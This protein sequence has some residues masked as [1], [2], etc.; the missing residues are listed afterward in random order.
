MFSRR[1]PLAGALAGLELATVAAGVVLQGS[2][3]I[4]GGANPSEEKATRT[5]ARNAL[6]PDS[7]EYSRSVSPRAMVGTTLQS[8]KLW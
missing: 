8:L 3:Q 4:A 7:L 5:R 6:A 2:A 1:P